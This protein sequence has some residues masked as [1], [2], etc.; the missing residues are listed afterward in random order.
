VF[1]SSHRHAQDHACDFDYQAMGRERLAKA[2]PQV[3]ASK[4][5]KL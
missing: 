4:I 2:N 5:D 1:C 3:A